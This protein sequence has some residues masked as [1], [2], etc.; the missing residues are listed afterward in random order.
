MY[1]FVYPD[2]M[3][4]ET[5]F[6]PS[7][8]HPGLWIWDHINGERS[9]EEEQSVPGCSFA[10]TWPHGSGDRH[11]A[12]C[13]GTGHAGNG[14]GNTTNNTAADISVWAPG[15]TVVKPPHHNTRESSIYCMNVRVRQS[16]WKGSAPVLR[17]NVWGLIWSLT[18]LK[19]RQPQPEIKYKNDTIVLFTLKTKPKCRSSVWK[20]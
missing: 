18:W 11:A 3:L 16:W 4:T 13:H 9:P 8:P 19:I 2:L 15:S 10:C 20:N 12:E 5:P 17:F 6:P 7:L 1:Q 14:Q